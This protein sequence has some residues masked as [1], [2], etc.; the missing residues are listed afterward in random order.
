[1]EICDEGY[2]KVVMI[3]GIKREIVLGMRLKD[4]EIYQQEEEE[5]IIYRIKGEICFF[6]IVFVKNK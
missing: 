2:L 1:M 5:L 4:R 3:I 6:F